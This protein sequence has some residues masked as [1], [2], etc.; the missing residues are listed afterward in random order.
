MFNFFING[1]NKPRYY[2]Q[3]FSTALVT[4]CNLNCMYCD[5][6]SPLANEKFYSVGE[7]KKQFERMNLVFNV[8]NI[9][10]M[11]GEPLLHPDIINIVKITRKIFKNSNILIYTN[12]ILLQSK[13][14]IF[15]KVCSEN[16]IIFHLSMYDIKL[17]IKKII[18]LFRKHNIRYFLN[19]DTNGQYRTMYKPCLDLS[20]QQDADD[21]YKSCWMKNENCIYLEDGKLFKCTIAGNVQHFNKYFNINLEVTPKDYLD[22]FSKLSFEQIDSYFSNTIDFCKYCNIQAQQSGLKFE[23]SNKDISEWT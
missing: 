13:S 3:Y 15:F 5:H 21:S 4:H 12:G 19:Y 1:K 11:G 6:F 17:D 2:L 18:D 7:L 9:G 22:I 20:G 14:D 10:L 23:I 16:G 8:Q